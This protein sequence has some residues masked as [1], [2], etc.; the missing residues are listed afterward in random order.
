MYI[1][2]T[3]IKIFLELQRMKLCSY[4]FTS[5]LTNSFPDIAKKNTLNFSLTTS[6][7]F[8]PSYKTKILF[9]FPKVKVQHFFIENFEWVLINS[10]NK[11]SSIIIIRFSN[12]IH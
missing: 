8:C 1:L 12:V 11:G 9:G 10:R 6:I 7:H 5:Q 2:L 4:I 3:F